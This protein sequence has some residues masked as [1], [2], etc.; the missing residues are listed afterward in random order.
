MQWAEKGSYR[1]ENMDETIKHLPDRSFDEKNYCIYSLD[2]FSV[3]ITPA[4]QKALLDRG[5]IPVLM[6]GGI[7]G[8]IQ[9]GISLI[10]NVLFWD[11][12]MF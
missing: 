2:N 6:G 8:D 1:Q 9:V 7:T 11:Y 4:T 5:Y 3:H 12:Q 10:F